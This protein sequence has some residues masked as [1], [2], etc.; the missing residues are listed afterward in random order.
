MNHTQ[1]KFIMKNNNKTEV[2]LFS[3]YSLTDLYHRELVKWLGTT[4]QPAIRQQHDLAHAEDHQISSN[5]EGAGQ[6]HQ[7]EKLV[8]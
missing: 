2:I 1:N 8:P 6:P 7:S 5:Y 3:K 4:L